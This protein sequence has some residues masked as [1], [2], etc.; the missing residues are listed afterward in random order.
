MRKKIL[1]L[2]LTASMTSA[3]VFSREKC[4][5]TGQI[6][7][8]DSANLCI[9]RYVPEMNQYGLSQQAGVPMHSHVSKTRLITTGEH[10]DGKGLIAWLT[11]TEQA[12]EAA[13]KTLMV[14]VRFGIYDSAYLNTYVT[15]PALRKKYLNRVGV[16]FVPY[17]G[18]K[19]EIRTMDAIT[20]KTGSGS[21]S[22]GGGGA[23]DFGGL[24][25]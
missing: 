7:N 14:S 20:P 10:F 18:S 24:E 1:F 25:P 12:Y 8:L 11:Q 13:G 6:V 2:L 4:D 3:F 5:T 23:Y 15:D 22:S 21:G 16:F 17:D 19:P 9:A